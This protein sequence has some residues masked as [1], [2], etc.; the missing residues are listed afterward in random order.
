ML[1]WCCLLQ[2]SDIAIA[3]REGADAVMLS[4]ET[5]YGKFPLKAV[6]T[7]STV[8]LRTE[9]AMMRYQVGLSYCFEHLGPNIRWY[10]QRNV[11]MHHM[12]VGP[13]GNSESSWWT[14]AA[15]LQ[16][17]L[18]DCHYSAPPAPSSKQLPSDG[19][20]ST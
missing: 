18:S 13:T 11:C 14:A 5:A 7:Q 15:V 10:M 9:A 4:G 8:A 3:V 6:V 19:V 12:P 16:Q 1:L 17:F 2:V 20:A